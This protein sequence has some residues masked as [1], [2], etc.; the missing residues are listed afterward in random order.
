LLT[1]VEA[2]RALERLKKIASK[3]E[4]SGIVGI[5]RT[6]GRLSGKRDVALFLSNNV[7]RVCINPGRVDR[8]R[9]L[10]RRLRNVS[11]RREWGCRLGQ[12]RVMSDRT[13]R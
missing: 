11:K 2:E 3:W 12:A 4:T 10:R 7:Y 13:K 5:K 9:G 8:R 6:S 1:K